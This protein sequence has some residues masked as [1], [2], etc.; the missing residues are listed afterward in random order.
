MT[1]KNSGDVRGFLYFLAQIDDVPDKKA[2][3]FFLEL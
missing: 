1:L 3:E 2:L